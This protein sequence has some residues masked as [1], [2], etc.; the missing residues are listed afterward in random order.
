[1]ALVSVRF[2]EGV[3][4]RARDGTPAQVRGLVATR[5]LLVPA[6]VRRAVAVRPDEHGGRAAGEVPARALP[7]ERVPASGADQLTTRNGRCVFASAVPAFRAV[8]VR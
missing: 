1:M 2:G 5:R 8:R 6:P 4:S 3:A 7:V